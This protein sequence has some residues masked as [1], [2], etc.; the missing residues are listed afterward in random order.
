MKKIALLA[1]VVFLIVDGMVQASEPA[2][3]TTTDTEVSTLICFADE[4]IRVWSQKVEM[5]S[6]L[7]GATMVFHF[8]PLPR[9]KSHEVK[10]AEEENVACL[11]GI[12]KDLVVLNS[13][14]LQ[15]QRSSR[16]RRRE[17]YE[18]PEKIEKLRRRAEEVIDLL[19]AYDRHRR[20]MR[21]L[22]EGR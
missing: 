15:A 3:I 20:N 6:D 4:Q 8:F 16:L 14:I 2:A 21:R 5:V 12:L 22:K 18:L 17:L 9:R 11:R 1:V 13:R 7:H 10:R 19:T